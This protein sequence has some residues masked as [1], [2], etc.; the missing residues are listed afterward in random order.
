MLESEIQKKSNQKGG[1]ESHNIPKKVQF[2]EI[3]PSD[4]LG[5]YPESAE[6]WVF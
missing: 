1:G 2:Q 5:T 3:A 4:G 6:K